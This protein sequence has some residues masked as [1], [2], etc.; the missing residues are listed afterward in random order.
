[1]KLL[2]DSQDVVEYILPNYNKCLLKQYKVSTYNNK[3][4]KLLKILYSDMVIANKNF[5]NNKKKIYITIKNKQ[6]FNIPVF[7]TLYMPNNI[8]EYINGSG[9]Y[10]VNYNFVINKRKI[11]IYIM[12]YNINENIEKYNSWIYNMYL[13]LYI[14]SI[15]STSECSK[16]L[17]I[18]LFPTHYKKILPTNTTTI[19]PANVNTAYT[20]RCQP[21][22][23][24]IIYRLEE[25]FKVFIHESIHSF[26]LDINHN[27]EENINKKLSE[28][29]S[30]NINFSISE[31]YTE[32]WARILNIAVA[33]FNNKN[34]NKNKSQ[35]G[36][37]YFISQTNFFLQLEKIFSIMQMNKV[38]NNMNLTYNLITNKSK[39]SIIICQNLYKEN[40]HV[41]GYYILTAIIINRTIE[42]MDY[43]MK[44]NPCFL[45]FN[46][47]NN[48]AN[49]IVKFIKQSYKAK[50]LTQ[51]GKN[52]DMDNDNTND[53]IKNNIRMSAIEFI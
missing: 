8:K 17:N 41:F 37:T 42:F 39:N 20:K 53:F 28:F 15:Y 7:A 50:M 2:K 3:S 30:V 14:C 34:K 52:N 25:W 4:S 47:T 45:K 19:G 21:N 46:Q 6:N 16:E 38:L 33:C 18:Y 35:D 49:E 1:M 26:G 44:N 22:G 36:E 13:I 9:F 32:S 27:I 40:T 11:N 12:I 48:N 31:A 29:F 24:I 10:Q 43:C 5:H 23:E 51:C